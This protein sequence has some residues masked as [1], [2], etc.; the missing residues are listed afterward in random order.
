M[1]IHLPLYTL[2][3]SAPVIMMKPARSPSPWSQLRHARSD[4]GVSDQSLPRDD[5]NPFFHR[6]VAPLLIN[7]V[8]YISPIVYN[9]AFPEQHPK[10]T[11]SLA[12]LG[13]GGR[14]VYLFVCVL[15][16][17]LA[18][19]DPASFSGLRRCLVGDSIPPV[20]FSVSVGAS[21]K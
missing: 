12:S 1:P 11:F 17:L 14:L 18:W 4:I 5:S 13:I 16:C 15:A 6:H 19:L 8:V 21:V 2:D 20:L 7:T 3:S 10:K 9:A